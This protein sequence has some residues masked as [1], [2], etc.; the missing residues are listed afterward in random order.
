MLASHADLRTH[1][2]SRAHGLA[3]ANLHAQH[4]SC[5]P[6]A[7]PVGSVSSLSPSTSMMMTAARTASPVSDAQLGSL[8]SRLAQLEE[9]KGAAEADVAQR[10]AQVQSI[11]DQ[12]QQKRAEVCVCGWMSLVGVWM[13]VCSPVPL[14][15]SVGE[16]GKSVASV[17]DHLP[18]LRAS[19]NCLIAIQVCTMMY[20]RT[21][22][23]T[24]ICTR[25]GDTNTRTH[26]L[27]GWSRRSLSKT[28]C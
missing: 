19:E 21:C 10:Q 23:C 6:G 25:T 1:M 16:G 5:H 18:P 14:S 22:V 9:K 13:G 3:P 4:P 26:R 12:V 7:P 8:D 24:C 27:S 2:A 11:N 17:Q 20:S 15:L 28:C